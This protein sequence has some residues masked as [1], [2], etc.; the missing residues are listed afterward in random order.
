MPPHSENAHWNKLSQ[1]GSIVHL[2][3]ISESSL[4]PTNRRLSM[5]R[6]KQIIIRS[7][8]RD[9]NERNF[10]NKQAAQHS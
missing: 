4:T 10:S 8:S 5:T 1:Y 3:F 7:S 6:S 2:A 9:D